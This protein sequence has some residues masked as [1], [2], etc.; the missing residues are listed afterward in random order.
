MYWKV[1]DNASKYPNEIVATYKFDLT[2]FVALTSAP[3]FKSTS[4][5]AV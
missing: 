2:L 1:T 5:A 3:A 4:A